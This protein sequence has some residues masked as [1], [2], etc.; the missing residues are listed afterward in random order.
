VKFGDLIIY[1]KKEKLQIHVPSFYFMQ[2]G[3][4]KQSKC[5]DMR[6]KVIIK[7]RVEINEIQNRIIIKR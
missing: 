5:K 2:L 3:N 4:A 1:I 6:R 7:I